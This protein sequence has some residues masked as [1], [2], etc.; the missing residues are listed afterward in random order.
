MTKKVEPKVTPK[1]KKKFVNP[2]SVSVFN[3]RGLTYS[4]DVPNVGLVRIVPGDNEFRDEETATLV[5]TVLNK[6]FEGANL[7]VK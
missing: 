2:S 7:I 3:P 1:E 4:F 6:Q 5:A